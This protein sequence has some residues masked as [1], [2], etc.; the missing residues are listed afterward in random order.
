MDERTLWTLALTSSVFAA[1]LTHGLGLFKDWRSRRRDADFA[2]LYVV[3][4]LE[5]YASRCASVAGDI[6]TYWSSKG[7]AGTQH[8]NVPE[9][10]DYGPDIEWKALGIKLTSKVMS[11]RVHVAHTRE[12][13][14]DLEEHIG[15]NIIEEAHEHAVRLGIEAIEIA[16]MI[17]KQRRLGPA[18]TGST[19]NVKGWLKEKAER[20]AEERA[21]AAAREAPDE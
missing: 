12:M 8:I 3:L 19:W 10:P 13:L 1:L 2:A 14:T 9:P 21:K 17:R 5:G 20:L 11:F 18:Q 7:A 4:V 15:E 16:E 6:S